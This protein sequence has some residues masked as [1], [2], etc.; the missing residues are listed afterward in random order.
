MSAWRTQVTAPEVAL[1]LVTDRRRLEGRDLAGLAREA[2]LAGVDRIQLREKDL[3]DGA[4]RALAAEVVAATAGTGTIVLVNGR[5]DVAVATRAAGV[6]LPE[7]GL[8]VKEVKRCFPGL[9]VGASRHSLEGVRRA[10]EEGADFV[11]LG[12]IFPSPGK[13]ERALGLEVLSEAAGS[14]AIPV[15]AIGGID[16]RT[17]RSAVEAGARGLAAIRAFLEGP[18]LPAVRALRGNE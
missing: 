15:H 2:S 17:A 14:V 11:L 6:Q 7:D 18:L 1:T 13:E 8:P 12:P 10:Q 4:L 16:R 5:P 9:L 3:P